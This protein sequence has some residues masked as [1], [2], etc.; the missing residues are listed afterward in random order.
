MVLMSMANTSCTADS[1]TEE[2]STQYAIGEGDT[3]GQDGSLTTPP[4]P[5][6]PTNP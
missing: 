6:P 2:T 4:P 3:G 5:P 1:V